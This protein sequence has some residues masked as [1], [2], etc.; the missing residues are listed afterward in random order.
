LKAISDVSNAILGHLYLMCVW[1][2]L[3]P[4]V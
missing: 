3:R 2:C 4:S 1:M